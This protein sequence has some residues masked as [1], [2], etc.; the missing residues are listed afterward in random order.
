M[1]EV[2][3]ARFSWIEEIE[4]VNA[5]DP[6]EEETILRAMLKTDILKVIDDL[7]QRQAKVEILYIDGDCNDRV[8]SK[9]G[10][11][12]KRDEDIGYRINVDLAN[13]DMTFKE[14]N[15]LIKSWGGICNL[16]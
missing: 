10:I 15:Q 16:A 1:L 8:V 11:I 14:F 4:E 3:Y 12:P 13:A 2:F 7:E 6:E 5:Y 9:E